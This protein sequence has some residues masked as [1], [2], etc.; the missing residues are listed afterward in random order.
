VVVLREIQG[1]SYREISEILEM[2]M[3]TLKVTLH[4]ARR[5]LRESL[6]G[7]EAHVVNG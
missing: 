7:A 4:R 2:R 5:K 1:L 3:S 6:K